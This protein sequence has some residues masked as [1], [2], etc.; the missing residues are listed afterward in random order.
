[1][2]YQIALQAKNLFIRPPRKLIQDWQ[3]TPK[4][5][6]SNRVI[7]WTFMLKQNG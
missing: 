2:I 6:V 4:M 7:K 3:I 1:M 5:I